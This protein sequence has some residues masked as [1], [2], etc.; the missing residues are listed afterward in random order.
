MVGDYFKLKGDLANTMDTALEIVKW[1][2]SHGFAL[3]LLRERQQ[4]QNGHLL[5]L[6]LAVVTRWTSR[7]LSCARL[8]EVKR[9]IR[10]LIYDKLEELVQSVG[11][12]RELQ[13]KARKVLENALDLHFWDNLEVYVIACLSLRPNTH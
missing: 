10:G 6:L 3:G 1:F 7:Y 4:Q 13:T 11:D 9:T 12:K 2:N 5:A 8:L